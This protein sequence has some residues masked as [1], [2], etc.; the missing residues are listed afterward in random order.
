MVEFSLV[1]PLFLLL[2]FSIIDFGRIIQ[3]NTTVAEAARQGARQAAANAATGDN[4]FGDNPNA[5]YAG[6][7]SGTVFTTNAT[8]TGCLTDAG[9]GATVGDLLARA[10]LDRNP[11]VSTGNAATCTSTYPVAGKAKI[12]IHPAQN[13]AQPNYTNCADAKAKLGHDPAPGD[14]GGRE[15]EYKSIGSSTGGPTFKGCFLVEVTVI[16]TYQPFTGIVSVVIGNTFHL[17][18]STS[19]VAEY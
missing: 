14:L 11:P 16:Y 10:G 8:G 18:S 6:P 19:T 5:P 15:D 3:A 9:I 1:A 4:P 17:V 13:G 12:C 2:A 7:C